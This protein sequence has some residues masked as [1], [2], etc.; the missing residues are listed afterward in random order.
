MYV[1]LDLFWSTILC[2]GRTDDTHMRII[3]P[4]LQWQQTGVRPENVQTA[5]KQGTCSQHFVITAFKRHQI[6]IWF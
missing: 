5:E 2:P 4:N 3:A 1:S 6:F